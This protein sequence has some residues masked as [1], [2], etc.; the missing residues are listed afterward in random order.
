MLNTIITDNKL[1]WDDKSLNTK[2]IIVDINNLQIKDIHKYLDDL[3][4]RD[5]FLINGY[6]IVIFKN[7]NNLIDDKSMIEKYSKINS[8]FGDFMEQNIN[9]ET[10]VAVKDRGKSMESGA[11][12][13]ETSKGGFMHTDSPQWVNTPNFVSL[14]CLQTAKIGGLGLYASVYSI[15]NY[16]LKYYPKYLKI[17]YEPFHFDK[18]NHIRNNE[19]L[20]TYRPIF[21]YNDSGLKMRYLYKYII[22]AY[23]RLR[24]RLTE[25]QQKALDIVNICIED[26]SNLFQ[27]ELCRGDV[28]IINNN[29]IIHGRTDFYDH[30]EIDK[31]RLLL[32]TWIK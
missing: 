27:Y 5:N 30:A 29:R 1:A 12:Y 9:N 26:K 17:L 19:E 16:L 8:Y 14:L 23:K 4:A 11:R 20:T 21:E 13:H 18:S 22:K 15:H 3:N 31:K 2:K 6:G 28:L 7:N 10:I 25:Q 24:L 32:R